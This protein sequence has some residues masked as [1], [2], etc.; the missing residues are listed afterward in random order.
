MW[1]KNWS[2]HYA[3]CCHSC[4]W[5]TLLK[6]SRLYHMNSHLNEI[7]HHSFLSNYNIHWLTES[8]FYT[9]SFFQN[10]SNYFRP[11]WHSLHSAAYCVVSLCD[12]D[13]ILFGFLR[14]FGKS[15]ASLTSEWIW[16]VC[17]IFLSEQDTCSKEH[18]VCPMPRTIALYTI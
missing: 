8:D 17:T 5:V 13:Y 16:K 14:F 7:L 3:S 6:N 1:N 15:T 9:T 12:S 4:C 10:G 18:G 2:C 11:V